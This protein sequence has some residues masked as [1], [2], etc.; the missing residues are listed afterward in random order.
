MCGCEGGRQEERQGDERVEQ[1]GVGVVPAGFLVS[2]LFPIGGGGA[3]SEA[4]PVQQPLQPVGLRLAHLLQQR[5][6]HV[7]RLVPDAVQGPAV[8][9]AM[10][11]QQQGVAEAPVVGFVRLERAHERWVFVVEENADLADARFRGGCR[12]GVGAGGRGCWVGSSWWD[13][14][15]GV[16][17][18]CSRCGR[19]GSK[20]ED[21]REGRWCGWCR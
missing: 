8:E 5:R 10:P 4:K 2:A 12:W 9:E 18:E 13:E 16:W 14:G 11:E 6:G 21:G 17:G 3:R 1:D 19:W 7:R 20:V 15:W